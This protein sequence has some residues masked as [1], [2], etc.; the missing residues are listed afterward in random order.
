AISTVIGLVGASATAS[1]APTAAGTAAGG[2][3]SSTRARAL[4]GPARMGSVSGP[5]TAAR[6]GPDIAGPGGPPPKPGSGSASG[7]QRGLKQPA[8]PASLVALRKL[9]QPKKQVRNADRQA[10]LAHGCERG[11]RLHQRLA[12]ATGF[13]DRNK[14]R[15]GEGEFGEQ[16]GEAL[17]VEVVDEMQ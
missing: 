17:G 13:R 3:A 8:E 5:G 7:A 10:S 9:G 16:R 2:G 4:A 12:G 11:H 6:Q 14:P 15:G 1:A